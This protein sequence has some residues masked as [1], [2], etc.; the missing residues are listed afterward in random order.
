MKI[1][2]L[3]LSVTL[4]L[5]F[6]FKK[7]DSDWGFFAHSRIN[8]LAVFTLPPDLIPFFK[9]H[10]IFIKKEAVAPDKRRYAS[11]HEEYRHYIDLDNFGHPPFDNLPRNW[12]DALVKK[13][14]IQLISKTGDTTFLSDNQTF[15][16]SINSKS[17]RRFYSRVIKKDYYEDTW[18]VN[19]DSLKTYPGFEN[20]DCKKA[21]V[22]DSVSENGIL[23]WHLQSMHY[24]L[25]KA[26]EEKDQNK[27]L[28]LAADFGH[29][30]GDAHVPLHTTSNYNGQQ[31]GQLGI[32]GFWESRLP[33]LF[34]E[35]NYD[36]WVGAAEYIEDK[37]AFYWNMVF[38]SHELVDSVLLI[39]KNLSLTFPK[40]QQYCIEE[41]GAQLIQTP[42]PAY[43]EA[44]HARMNGMVE[45]RMR[46]AI[47][48]IGC[49]WYS[50][51]VDAGSPDLSKI[52]LANL[53]E[54]EIKAQE[55][56]EKAFR[57]GKIKGRSHDN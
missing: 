4:L 30:I 18:T 15:T 54:E 10:I 41:R 48:R 42:C 13:T 45:S 47:H 40:E 33:E 7:S 52:G 24:R 28:R 20:L 49:A 12:I 43:A 8:E 50:A 35:E 25:M 37:E 22:I 26:F 14:D 36:F 16:D 17:Y 31:T 5:L 53:S 1:K 3:L 21:I 23:P 55:E 51:W 39:E 6:S 46:D 9:K 34:A 38:E 56:L 27:I 57:E 44:F 2:F 11:P 29:Y 19:P 32:H